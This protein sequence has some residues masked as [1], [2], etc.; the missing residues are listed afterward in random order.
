MTEDTFR[1]MRRNK[2]QLT[3]SESRDILTK[4]TSGVLALLGDHGYPYA[5]PLSFVL[6]ENLLYF[7]SAV[8]GHKIEAVRNDEKASFCVIG[9]DNVCGEKFSTDYRSVIAFGKISVVSDTDERRLALTL[10]ADKYSPQVAEPEVRATLDSAW[11]RVAILR[12]EIR[13]LSGKQ[14]R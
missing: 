2:Q 8:E 6:Y 9:Q 11:N 13:N 12:F 5:V 3:D 14:A 7:H 1:P 10:L 4:A